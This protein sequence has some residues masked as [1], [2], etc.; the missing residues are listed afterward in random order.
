VSD[1][2]TLEHRE[3]SAIVYVRQSTQGQLKHNLESRRLQYAMKDKVAQLGW[4]T[5]RIEIIDDDLGVT[6][7]GAAHRPG[8]EQLMAKV[9]SGGVGLVAAREVSRLAR[10]DVDW[11]RLLEICRWTG[12]MVLD[13]ETVYDTRLADDRLLLGVKGN[14]SA[15]ELDIWRT[16][17]YD[18]RILKAS[19]GEFVTTPPVGF[20]KGKGKD[21]SRLELDPDRRVQ[22]VIRLVFKKLEELGSVYQ[23]YHWFHSHDVKLPKRHFGSAE[24]RVEW[25]PATH[26]ALYQMVIN[27]TYAGCYVYGRRSIKR[28]L[29]DGKMHQ[30]KTLT[31]NM[32]EWR[33][34]I[35][36]HFPGYISLETFMKIKAMLAEN[37]QKCAAQKG[38]GGAAKR[39]PALFSG[40][41]RCH[42]CGRKMN[43]A[44]SGGYNKCYRYSCHPF[45]KRS[46]AEC[47]TTFNGTDMEIALCA[48]ALRV[49][50][51]VAVDAA[52]RAFTVY[53]GHYRDTLKT[54]SRELEQAEYEAE[55]VR[56]QY[57]AV[58]P[59]NRQVAGE[60]EA[61]WNRALEQVQTARHRL[62]ERKEQYQPFQYS[63]DD[64]HAM[65][66]ALPEIWNAPE[67]EVR[68][69]KRILRLLI[70]DVVVDARDRSCLR[71]IIHWRGGT[72]TEENVARLLYGQ[73]RC[74]TPAST[75]EAVRELS[76]MLTDERVAKYL[77]ESGL[78]NARGRAWNGESV[79]TLRQVRKIP[80][81]SLRRRGESGWLTLTEAAAFVGISRDALRSA[82]LHGEV[83]YRHPLPAGPYLFKRE[84]LEGQCGDV[85][86]KAVAKRKTQKTTE[87]QANG[88][89]FEDMG[90]K[91]AV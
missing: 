46:S 66:H 77:N 74:D 4:P 57:D 36:N 30:R 42:R 20:V 11:Q 22:G 79:K 54:F 8:F 71:L 55:R 73:H 41:I 82:A 28:E 9:L 81:H 5:D 65:G 87:N 70:E 39:G 2:I 60:L 13:N 49:V 38:S 32:E 52:A 45:G 56:R 19:R 80:R 14:V 1:K 12:T 85:L 48:A 72:H 7:S 89:L 34:F 40:L 15:Y 83:A 51:T 50:D 91:G 90:R 59:E 27:P 88:G 68:L 44:Y 17:A 24:Q 53:D 33:F 47:C 35:P 58:E 29:R 37:S 61:R 62:E 3:K 31:L 25:K 69:K 78:K 75:V 10:N 6:A 67:T 86:R 23:V 26:K 43:V 63:L 64:F 84:D 18:A 76:V 21:A 16:R